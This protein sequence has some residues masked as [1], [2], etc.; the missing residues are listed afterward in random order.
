MLLL[1]AIRI[2]TN[3]MLVHITQMRF[4]AFLVHHLINF[5]A[6]LA[7]MCLDFLLLEA[8][9]IK[10]KFNDLSGQI[11]VFKEVM[12]KALNSEANGTA[13]IREILCQ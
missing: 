3:A 6:N 8:Q 12:V 13:Q 9:Q 1:G 10:V 11:K 5:M 7:L 4:E 2:C